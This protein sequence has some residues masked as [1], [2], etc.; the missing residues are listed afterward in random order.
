MKMAA[1][2]GLLVVA[3]LLLAIAIWGSLVLMGKDVWRSDQP[4]ARQIAIAM[5]ACYPIALCLIGGAVLFFLQG[6]GG[7]G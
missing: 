2:P 6:R 5:Q 7:K 3:V 4:G 1:V